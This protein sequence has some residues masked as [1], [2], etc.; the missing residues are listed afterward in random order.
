MV[1]L[2]FH[3]KKCL[4]N[5]RARRVSNSESILY[6]CLERDSSFPV[7][8]FVGLVLFDLTRDCRESTIDSRD[9]TWL[10]K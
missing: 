1:G 3:L 2:F 7:G 10:N 4:I 6:F 8:F 9:A 5:L